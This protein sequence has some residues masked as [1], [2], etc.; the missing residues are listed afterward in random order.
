MS[1]IASQ[2]TCCGYAE[3]TA[4]AAFLLHNLLEEEVN[5]YNRSN[6]FDPICDPSDECHGIQIVLLLLE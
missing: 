3:C 6:P 2:G 4:L 5:E 1:L